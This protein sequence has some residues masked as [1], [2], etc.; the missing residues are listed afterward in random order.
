MEYLFDSPGLIPDR[1][2]DSLAQPRIGVVTSSDPSS[3]T[4]RILLQ[5]EEV[6]T[7]WI[8]V[9]TNWCG[10]G[11]GITCPPCPGDQVLVLPQE[12]D[13][14]HGLIIGRLFSNSVR[15]PSAEPGELT[16]KHQSG[17]SIRLLNSGIIAMEGDLHV[18]GDV[19]DRHGSLSKLRNDFNGHLHRYGRGED[20]SP[21][22]ALD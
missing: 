13:A 15:P 4:A 1:M 20:T 21:P 5:P 2:R 8:P 19:F 16:I 14:Q 22:V 18:T 3:A 11:W 10:S 7:G 12:G 9:L 17:C 6:L